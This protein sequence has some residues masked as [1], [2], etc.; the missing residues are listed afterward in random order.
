MKF[1]TWKYPEQ[2]CEIKI[3]LQ[4]GRKT[5]EILSKNLQKDMWCIFGG[6]FFRLK[7]CLFLFI[8]LI[9]LPNI[10]GRDATI[11]HAINVQ[12]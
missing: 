6:H 1:L 4:H 12:F 7:I 10:I 2:N 5:I 3:M 11:L 9:L 8:F